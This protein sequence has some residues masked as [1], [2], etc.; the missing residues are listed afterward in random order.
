MRIYIYIYIHKT[1][2]DLKDTPQ[3]RYSLASLFL[4]LLLPAGAE[5]QTGVHVWME[6]HVLEPGHVAPEDLGL[7]VRQHPPHGGHHG[8]ALVG[9]QGEAL[10]HSHL[11]VLVRA[12]AQELTPVCLHLRGELGAV[13]E[14]R[15]ACR[16]GTW[17]MSVRDMEHVGQGH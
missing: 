5:V 10:H 14:L 8:V 1:L 15:G 3:C 16:S 6:E 2:Q 13:W 12:A 7:Q 11:L 17:S 9:E 4:I